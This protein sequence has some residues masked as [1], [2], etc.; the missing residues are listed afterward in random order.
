MGLLINGDIYI[1]IKPEIIE[2]NVDKIKKIN[3]DLYDLSFEEAHYGIT[4]R[5]TTIKEEL[6]EMKEQL[7]ESQYDYKDTEI[8]HVLKIAEDNMKLVGFNR[9][10]EKQINKC[11]IEE[12]KDKY[13]RI[14]EFLKEAIYIGKEF[15]RTQSLDFLNNKIIDYMNP[16][17]NSSTT[18]LYK[19]D[20]AMLALYTSKYSHY[21]EMINP[22]YF[23]DGNY[24]FFGKKDNKYNNK[25]E[26]YKNIV[27]EIEDR[28]EYYKKYYKNK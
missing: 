12:L 1:K 5:T 13:I 9:L 3:D 2:P 15:K 6:E 26:M 7:L 16:E 4:E 21:L 22:N 8:F 20:Y 25:K 10:G 18:I 11:S 19:T 14:T 23:I 28:Y 24:T 27:D 17:R